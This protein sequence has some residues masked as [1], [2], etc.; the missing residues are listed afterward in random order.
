MENIVYKILEHQ[1]RDEFDNLAY[2]IEDYDYKYYNSI[3]VK[4]LSNILNYYGI[5]QAKDV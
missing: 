2:I 1:Y 4:Q 3:N 5:S